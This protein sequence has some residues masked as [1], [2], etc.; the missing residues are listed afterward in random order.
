MS[1]KIWLIIGAIVLI[2]IVSSVGT[3]NSLVTKSQ[4]VETAWSQVETDYQRRADLVPNLVSTVKGAA[5]FEQDT[6]TAV[7]EARA[8]AT[9]I[10]LDADN[11]TPE[12]LAEFQS[13][14]S[15]LSGALS[16]LL[17][18]AESYPLLTATESFRG[19]QTQ[20]EG[21][22]NRIA[23]SRKDFNA[24]VQDY[25]TSLRTFPTVIIGSLLG[26]DTKPYFES[27]SGAEVVPTV[28]F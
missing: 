4:A 19:L 9:G 25:N 5:S 2:A 20:L 11:L 1:K 8:K 7:V 15:G 26:F 18:V 22:E 21:T 10:N 14:Q 12:R 6:L 16:R 17:V 3:Y 28:N 13:A 27:A 23:V 24:T